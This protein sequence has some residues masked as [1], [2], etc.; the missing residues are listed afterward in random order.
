MIPDLRHHISRSSNDAKR[1]SRSNKFGGHSH[2]VYL[3]APEASGAGSLED[4][5][6]YGEEDSMITDQ[7]KS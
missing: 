7:E 4:I 6:Q 5:A 2:D 1:K 3:P